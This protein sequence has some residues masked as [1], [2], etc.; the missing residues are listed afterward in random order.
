LDPDLNFLDEAKPYL[1]VFVKEEANV[2][3]Q[4]K[5][6]AA[7]FGGSLVDIPPL[8]ERV[9]TRAERGELA[10]KIPVANINDA[11]AANTKAIRLLST[12]IIFGFAL[13]TSV[14]LYANQFYYEAKYGYI[15]TGFILIIMLRQSLTGNR[16]RLKA[17]HSPMVFRRGRK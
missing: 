16:K 9:L 2:W 8:L 12:S 6:K 14:Y 4:F 3:N 11:I 13:F 7:R 5:E 10:L 17:P 1:K 15:G